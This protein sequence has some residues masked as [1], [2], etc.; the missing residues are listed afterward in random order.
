MRARQASKRRWLAYDIM[1][2][3]GYDFHNA[4][5][6]DWVDFLDG[7][8]WLFRVEEDMWSKKRKREEA[9]QPGRQQKRIELE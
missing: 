8:R 7:L 5:V 4:M 2:H 9:N 3:N 6:Q 1:R